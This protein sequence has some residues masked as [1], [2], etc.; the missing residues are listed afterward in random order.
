MKDEMPIPLKLDSAETL[1]VKIKE[2]TSVSRSENKNIFAVL[3]K[4]N[5]PI[6]KMS[7]STLSNIYC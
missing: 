2:R 4:R 3:V 1:L 6:K 5:A 7:F